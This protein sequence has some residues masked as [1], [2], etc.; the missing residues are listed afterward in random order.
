MTNFRSFIFLLALSSYIF[1]N[2]RS[3]SFCRVFG[4]FNADVVFFFMFIRSA[5]PAFYIFFKIFSSSYF[6]P[7]TKNALKLLDTAC[8]SVCNKWN[9]NLFQTTNIVAVRWLISI[10]YRKQH[11]LATVSKFDKHCKYLCRALFPYKGY[12]IVC[13]NN[14]FFSFCSNTHRYWHNLITI[15]KKYRILI[16]NNGINPIFNL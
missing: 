9:N 15:I 4:F 6:S 2:R 10:I 11:R 5:L 14:L 12:T 8:H 1:T 13:Q 16:K 3:T 7:N